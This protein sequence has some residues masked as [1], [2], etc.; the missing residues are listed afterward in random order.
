MCAGKPPSR[1]RNQAPKSHK[2]SPPDRATNDGN[3]IMKNI[4]IKFV[5]TAASALLFNACTPKDA[6]D[7]ATASGKWVADFPETR[8]DPFQ[9]MDGGIA[10][11]P[12]EIAGRNTWMLWTGG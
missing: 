6:V 5:V 11:T 4:S 1:Y 3:N 12:D 10:L 8:T 9:P 2:P 7:E